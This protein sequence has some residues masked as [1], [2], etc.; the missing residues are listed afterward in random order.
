[1][2]LLSQAIIQINQNLKLINEKVFLEQQNKETNH[3]VH[4]CPN[5]EERDFSKVQ[6]MMP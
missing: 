2:S 5:E 1:M 6:N 3:M 4:C